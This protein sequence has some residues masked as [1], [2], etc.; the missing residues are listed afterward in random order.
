[1][2]T[3]T[4]ACLLKAALF[5]ES[6][7]HLLDRLRLGAAGS[8][9]AG[10]QQLPSL[11]SIAARQLQPGQQAHRPAAGAV[12]RQQAGRCAWRIQQGFPHRLGLLLRQHC[13]PTNGSVEPAVK[14]LGCVCQV[15]SQQRSPCTQH[16]ISWPRGRQQASEKD[17]QGCCRGRAGL[18]TQALC[19]STGDCPLCCSWVRG[20]AGWRAGGFNH[21]A[22]LPSLVLLQC[23]S[24]LSPFGQQEHSLQQQRQRAQVWGCHACAGIP[25][26]RPDPRLLVQPLLEPW[27]LGRH[28]QLK[29]LR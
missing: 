18:P 1:M 9:Q 8:L 15:S 20:P 28:L 14:Q 12:G 7:H 27:H 25:Q 4:P 17:H 23:T 2:P 11:R 24:T 19:C 21:S 10:A 26:Q 16:C 22:F 5:K 29:H 3:A 13:C 6:G